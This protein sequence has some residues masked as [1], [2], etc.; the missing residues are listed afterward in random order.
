VFF[1]AAPLLNDDTSRPGHSVRCARQRERESDHGWDTGEDFRMAAV[2]RRSAA[3]SDR[4]PLGDS[5]SQTR[6]AP[7]AGGKGGIAARQLHAQARCSNMHLASASGRPHAAAEAVGGGC[8]EARSA[9]AAPASDRACAHGRGSVERSAV[10][11]RALSGAARAPSPGPGLAGA[12]SLQ[13]P[14]EALE[15]LSLI[16]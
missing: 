4:A 6:P 7:A 2:W 10:L 1:S 5:T 8:A 15:V 14:E 11:E 16:H 12:A 3:A 13:L 9:H